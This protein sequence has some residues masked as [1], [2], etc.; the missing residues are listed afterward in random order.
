MFPQ[1]NRSPRYAKLE[2]L[3]NGPDESVHDNISAPSTKSWL[4][5]AV[6]TLLCILSF[7]AGFSAGATWGASDTTP[8]RLPD[9]IP[10]LPV[11]GLS[12]Q[13]IRTLPEMQAAPPANGTHEPAWDRLIPNGL[14]YVRHPTLA[15]E[16]S[17]IGIFHQ[18]HCLYG[19]RR[20]YYAAY[21][22]ANGQE[23]DNAGVREPKHVAHCLDY[24]Q[25]SL[26]CAADT[27]IEPFYGGQK[28]PTVMFARQCR[29]FGEIQEWAT[30]WRA[31]NG[32]GF[33]FDVK[34]S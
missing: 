4:V 1:W 14:G 26:V 33:M 28:Y 15:P 12:R 6:A 9:V 24:L 3:E 31:V 11:N 17:V 18:L 8:L 10:S 23:F 5:A 16:F 30:Q 20:A 29:D 32:S 22:A 25:Q 13:E 27:G 34:S 2:K 19:V 21:A 7:V